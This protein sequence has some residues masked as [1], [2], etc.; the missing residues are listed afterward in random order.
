MGNDYADAYKTLRA[1][2][3]PHII[4]SEDLKN[5][6]PKFTVASDFPKK[7]EGKVELWSLFCDELSG[8]V[9]TSRVKYEVTINVSGKILVDF[10]S[11]DLN[12]AITFYN[13]L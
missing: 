7:L 2:K 13:G 5:F 4:R 11:Y 9:D 1:K 12:E 6:E 3:N 8:W 10:E